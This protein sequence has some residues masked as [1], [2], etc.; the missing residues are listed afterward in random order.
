[1]LLCNTPV[2]YTHWFPF[3]FQTAEKKRVKEGEKKTAVIKIK[4]E[5]SSSAYNI[6]KEAA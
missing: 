5:L 2:N 6:N 4:N 3:P 1:M